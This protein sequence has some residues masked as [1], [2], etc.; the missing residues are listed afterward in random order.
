MFGV[1]PERYIVRKDKSSDI[2]YVW[3]WWYERKVQFYTTSFERYSFF[4][5]KNIMEERCRILNK[6][7]YLYNQAIMEYINASK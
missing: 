3:D 5:T 6:E 1:C 2:Y 4:R 7:I